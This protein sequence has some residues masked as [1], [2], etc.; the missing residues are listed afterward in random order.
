MIPHRT[1]APFAAVRAASGEPP[2]PTK[3]TTCWNESSCR[4]SSFQLLSGQSA[5]ASPFTVSFQLPIVQHSIV[6]YPYMVP[7]PCREI[8]GRCPLRCPICTTAKL[9]IANFE[10]GKC[11]AGLAFAY[12]VG[13]SNGG[14]RGTGGNRYRGG[15]AIVTGGQHAPPRPALPGPN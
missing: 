13:G 11:E 1:A 9:T 4:A 15:A 5:A 2:S 10:S 6:V 12:R 3:R 8:W 14:G 7:N